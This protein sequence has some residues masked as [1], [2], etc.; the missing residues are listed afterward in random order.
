MFRF[1]CISQNFQLLNF[2]GKFKCYTVSIVEGFLNY[3]F[4]TPKL[5][6]WSGREI[7]RNSAVRVE[8]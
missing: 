1:P 2:A 6:I 8:T 5:E 7:V 4:F 3:F